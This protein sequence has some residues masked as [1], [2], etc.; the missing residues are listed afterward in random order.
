MPSSSAVEREPLKLRVVGSNPTWATKGCTPMRTV[1]EEAILAIKALLET[2]KPIL[3][4]EELAM[5]DNADGA[6]GGA[7]VNVGIDIGERRLADQIRDMMK[8]SGVQC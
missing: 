4:E 5:I 2:I 3:P 8:M 1:E 7:P 6:N